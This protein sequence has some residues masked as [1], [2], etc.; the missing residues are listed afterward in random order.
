MRA[1][2]F[3]SGRAQAPFSPFAANNIFARE[4]TTL[5]PAL[6]QTPA[7]KLANQLSYGNKNFVAK[8]GH[9]GKVAPSFYGYGGVGYGNGF[10]KIVLASFTYP[11]WVVPRTQP[12]QKVTYEPHEGS[13]L[14][15]LQSMFLNVPLPELSKVP[16]GS[17]TSPGNDKVCVVWRPSTDEMWEMYRLK[18]ATGETETLSG[19]A[20]YT[21]KFGAYVPSVSKFNGIIPGGYGASATSLAI[22]GGMISLQDLIEVL[23][24]GEINHALSVSLSST[25]GPARAPATRNDTFE[26]LPP[27]HE[28]SANPAYGG[29]DA[30]QESLWCRFPA[31]KRA[32]A[33]GIVRAAQPVAW[34]I[35]EAIRRFGLYVA[36]SG[37]TGIYMESPVTLGS[38]FSFA[39]V[40]PLPARL[41]PFFKVPATWADPTLP[42]LEEA[43][44]GE[45]NV[46]TVQPWQEL[47]AIE[48]RAS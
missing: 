21:M 5:A 40:N 16:S 22:L 8:E 48:G 44:S 27:E 42:A 12:T 2:M 23:R 20:P 4:V 36:E 19:E 1:R 13:A 17:L 9:N 45:T 6:D 32:S 11:V 29:L 33:Y 47:E 38:P 35:N 41:I 43:L 31:A 7:Y 24:G 10:T 46:C 28:G 3:G 18:G 37:G 14:E 15:P 30:V 39:K 25:T 26:G 34:A